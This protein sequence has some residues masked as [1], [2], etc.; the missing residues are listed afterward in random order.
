MNRSMLARI[1]AGERKGNACEAG[2]KRNTTDDKTK[3][4]PKQGRAV[5][6]RRRAECVPCARPIAVSSAS[7]SCFS[8]T[9][10]PMPRDDSASGGIELRRHLG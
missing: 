4:N 8:R 6:K 1:S 3:H 5:M 2:R 10:L 7:L 9:A